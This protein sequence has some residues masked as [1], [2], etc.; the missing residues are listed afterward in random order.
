MLADELWREAVDDRV[1]VS[2]EDRALLDSRWKAYRAGKV[3]RI[4]LEELERRLARK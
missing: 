4:S 2:V 1:A 3:E